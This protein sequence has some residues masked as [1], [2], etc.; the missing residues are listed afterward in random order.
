MHL[1]AIT[2]DVPSLQGEDPGPPPKYISGTR[3]R[4]STPTLVETDQYMD[5]LEPGNPKIT[6]KKPSKNVVRKRSVWDQ[7]P[8]DEC[9]S[10]LPQI[11]KP[12]AEGKNLVKMTEL[13]DKLAKGKSHAEIGDG[14]PMFFLLRTQRQILKTLRGCDSNGFGVPASSAGMSN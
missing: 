8:N 2:S 5:L 4:R 9:I 14:A 7:G 3:R 6:K 11:V 10:L 13:N 1:K 12:F